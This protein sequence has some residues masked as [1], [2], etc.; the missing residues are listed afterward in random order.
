MDP[1]KQIM[2][3][4]LGADVN[5]VKV[6]DITGYITTEGIM[7]GFPFTSDILQIKDKDF[8]NFM[9]TMDPYYEGPETLN[10]SRLDG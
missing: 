4:G 6:D 1:N 5:G 2:K 7:L 8:G 10:L 3:A 9:R